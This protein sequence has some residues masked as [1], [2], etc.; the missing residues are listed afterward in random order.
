M[1]SIFRLK[2]SLIKHIAKE[3]YCVIEYKFQQFYFLFSYC[4]T[5]ISQVTKNTDFARKPKPSGTVDH[6]RTKNHEIWENYLYAKL[7]STNYI[8]TY[9]KQRYLNS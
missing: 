8:T 3:Q 1:L 6:F 4:H 7:R 2:V 5:F 9:Q